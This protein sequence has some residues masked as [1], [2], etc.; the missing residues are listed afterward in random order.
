[1]RS[2]FLF[3]LVVITNFASAQK[4]IRFIKFSCEG[5]SI[6]C[7]GYEEYDNNN[8]LISKSTTEPIAFEKY[9]KYNSLGQLIEEKIFFSEAMTTIHHHYFYLDS[10]KNWIV[11]SLLNE[12]TKELEIITSHKNGDN[13]YILQSNKSKSETTLYFDNKEE[14]LYKTICTKIQQ[15]TTY[16]YIYEDGH[17]IQEEIWNLTEDSKVP[18]LISK[19]NHLYNNKN[20]LGSVVLN[21]EERCLYQIKKMISAY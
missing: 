21:A 3:A 1:M 13:K 8:W 12:Q 4:H 7:I 15:C 2:V 5:D 14:L 20:Y 10:S 9:F 6:S 19:T 18:F 16:K 11:D 17:L